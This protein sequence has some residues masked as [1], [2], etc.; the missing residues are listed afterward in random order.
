[1][2]GWP[3]TWGFPGNSQEPG[4]ARPKP[5]GA[6][7]GVRAVPGWPA[8][9]PVLLTRPP[10]GSRQRPLCLRTFPWPRGLCPRPVLS[11]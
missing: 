2:P 10:A 3:R 8:V 5:P 11:G 1:M 7:G 9:R 6:V 4:P